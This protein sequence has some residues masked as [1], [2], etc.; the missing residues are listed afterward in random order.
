MI[1]LS[2]S[3]AERWINC[4]GS[5]AMCKDIPYTSSPAAKMGN[6]AHALVE[7]CLRKRLSEV[8]PHFVNSPFTFEYQ[9]T[10]ETIMVTSEMVDAA[11]VFLSE[12][13]RQAGRLGAGTFLAVERPVT[14]SHIHPAMVGRSYPFRADVA[15]FSSREIVVMDFKYGFLPVHL[16]T[17]RAIHPQLLCYATG[18]ADEYLWLHDCVTLVIV[19]PRSFEVPPVQTATVETDFLYDWTEVSLKQSAAATQ[20]P[21]APLNAG[22]WCR[23]CP[24]LAVCPA[25]KAK[26]E[27]LAGIEFSQYARAESC[28]ACGTPN[29]NCDMECAAAAIRPNVPT[30]AEQISNVLTWTP[31]L[32]AWL[33]SVAAYAFATMQRGETIP[34]HKIVRGKGRREWSEDAETKLLAAGLSKADIYEPVEAPKLKSPHQLEETVK[35]AKAIVKEVSVKIQGGL[36]LA[37]A[38][39]RRQAVTVAN[40]FANYAVTD[41]DD[42]GL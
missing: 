21:N 32:D 18:L 9:R 30:S 10:P 29:A 1:H 6:A 42:L 8:P 19:Q 14:L 20:E 4:P 16:R 28:G 12:V 31:I 37:H 7:E 24:A 26:A 3:T 35:G 22:D 34:D 39:D 23:W 36:T 25:V 15:L 17:E 11:N 13:W 5:S 2:P 40:E 33:R 38:S 27:E 41:M